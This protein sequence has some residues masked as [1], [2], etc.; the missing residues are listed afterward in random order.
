MARNDWY[1]IFEREREFVVQ[2]IDPDDHTPQT[3]T[4]PQNLPNTYTI[5]KEGGNAAMCSCFAG[6]K[7]CRHKKMLVKFQELNRV[8]ERWLY[9]FDKD[10]WIEPMEH[11]K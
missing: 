11:D 7:W 8:N 9:N 5:G 3:D 4:G 2:K 6:H 10:K 1:T